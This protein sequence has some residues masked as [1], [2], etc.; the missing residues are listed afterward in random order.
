MTDLPEGT[1]PAKKSRKNQNAPR[2]APGTPRPTVHKEAPAAPDLIQE[3]E[4][5]NPSAAS[6]KPSTPAPRPVPLSEQLGGGEGLRALSIG[7]TARLVG[8][9]RVNHAL[10]GTSRSELEEKTRSL[11]DQALD[12]A[13]HDLRALFAPLVERG[14]KDWQFTHLL[15]HL[16]SSL[17]SL[18]HPEEVVEALTRATQKLRPALFNR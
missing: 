17:E 7:I 18:G 13:D 15:T 4:S 9:P 10:F 16:K 1:Q 14:F 5:F 3:P 8:D 6:P 11:I 12:E 2:K